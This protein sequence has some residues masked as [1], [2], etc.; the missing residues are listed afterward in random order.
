VKLRKSLG[1]RNPTIGGSWAA[2]TRPWRF[3]PTDRG[4]GP[5]GLGGLVDL[6]AEGGAEV[7][8]PVPD[9]HLEVRRHRGVGRGRSGGGGG[10]VGV[11]TSPPRKGGAGR[12]LDQPPPSSTP[13]RLAG[14]DVAVGWGKSLLSSSYPS[15]PLRK[16]PFCDT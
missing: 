12:G 14:V 9:R 6:V 3:G 1:S 7:A 13:Y 8:V 15:P 2:G 5:P 11:W 10:L 4:R 16:H